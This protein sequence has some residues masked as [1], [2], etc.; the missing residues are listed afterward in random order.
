MG[1][2]EFKK[3]RVSWLIVWLFIIIPVL[4]MLVRAPLLK[5]FDF[6]PEKP[7]EEM[8]IDAWWGYYSVAVAVTA[9]Y[10]IIVYRVPQRFWNGTFIVNRIP[11]R[12]WK[13]LKAT[14]WDT[15]FDMGVF[16]IIITILMFTLIPCLFTPQ[17]ISVGLNFVALLGV[18]L[19]IYFGH[20]LLLRLQCSLLELL[21]IT[22]TFGLIDGLVLSTPGALKLGL[23]LSPTLAA[24]ILYAAVSGIVTATLSGANGTGARLLHIFAAMLSVSAFAL[25]GLGAAILIASESEKYGMSTYRIWAWPLIAAGVIGFGLNIRLGIKTK[26]HAQAL[27]KPTP[28]SVLNSP[29]LDAKP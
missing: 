11:Q 17:L 21:A 14:W 7:T 28:E 22:T 12:L 24:W 29:V 1:F 20:L 15:R 2:L 3:P 26:K 23:F 8:C 6:N 5:L 18:A 10:A 27:L 4:L 25:L 9:L 16:R 13:W 19:C